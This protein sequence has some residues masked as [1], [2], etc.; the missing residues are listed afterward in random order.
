MTNL[1]ITVDDETLQRARIR[2]LE[3]GTSVE[4]LLRDHLESFAGRDDARREAHTRL[5]E[6]SERA[7][8]RRGGN[9]WT[10][11]DLHES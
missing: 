2:A 6:R 4:A 3:N 11:D 10:R 9:T 7:T 8:S 1:T 5:L